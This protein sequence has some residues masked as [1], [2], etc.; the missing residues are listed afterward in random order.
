MNFSK[1][2][3]AFIDTGVAFAP[4]AAD[5]AVAAAAPGVP[6][7]ASGGVARPCAAGLAPGALPCAAPAGVLFWPNTNI[8]ATRL[9]GVAGGDLTFCSWACL[10]AAIP[11][12]HDF[13]PAAICGSP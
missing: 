8:G 6:R 13:R 4:V 10:A 12:T 1:P 2:F 9:S 3:G 7:V 5:A 11:A